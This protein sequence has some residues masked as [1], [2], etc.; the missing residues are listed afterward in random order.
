MS[1]LAEA[2]RRHWPSY[3]LKYGSRIPPAHTRAARAIERCRT[4]EAGMVYYR[5]SKCGRVEVA[6]L[7]CGHRACNQCGQHKALQW[8]AR[9]KARLLPV[10]YHLV[11]FTVP[12][13]FRSFFRA[14]QRL[15]Y[16]L[17]FRESAGALADLAADPRHLGGSIG[18]SGVLQTWTRELRFHPHI[19]YLV[20]AGALTAIGWVRPKNPDILLPVKPLAVRM[21][22]RF[23][24]ALKAADFKLY[25]TLPSKAWAKAWN[26]DAR[27]VGSGERAF[28][29]L[30]RYT[31]KTALDAARILKVTERTVTI[32]WIDRQSGRR[33]TAALE[34]HQFLRRFLQ[35]V[36][37]RGFVRLRHF[38][39]L[40][41]AARDTY[42][43]IRWLLEAP[44]TRQLP[45]ELAPPCCSACGQPLRFLCVL[46]PSQPRAP[47]QLIAR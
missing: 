40:S 30:A 47:P 34:G 9:Q 45:K 17:F 46:R 35:H 44:A 42:Q 4:P 33:R 32:G 29:Y 41:P 13:E 12:S 26:V 1:A 31:Q 27:A 15:C 5:C 28:E 36:L 24:A 19:H 2:V 10:P 11:T 37:P 23:R 14:H 7:S 21:R 43:H 8:E 39:F 20:P 22:N 18:L 25:L 3:A 6:P 38:G 16:D